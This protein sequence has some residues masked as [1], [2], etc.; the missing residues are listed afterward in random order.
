MNAA[1]SSWRAAKNVGEPLR[2]R[3][4]RIGSIPSPEN[5][6]MRSTPQAASRATRRSP[7]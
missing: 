5:P 1:D 2:W 3:A 7:T 6:K 4:A